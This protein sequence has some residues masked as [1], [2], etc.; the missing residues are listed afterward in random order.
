MK[1]NETITLDRHEFNLLF[2]NIIANTVF[3]K[4]SDKTVSE[5]AD[6][7]FKEVI[8]DQKH[9]PKKEQK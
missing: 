8:E 9:K 2:L 4:N 7:V 3:H 1:R 6:K 5:I